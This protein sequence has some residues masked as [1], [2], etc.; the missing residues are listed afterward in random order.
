MQIE[1]TIK[2]LMID[3]V[4]NSPSSSFAIWRGS[5]C[6]RSGSGVFEAN[7]IAVQIEN[8]TLPR[9]MTHDLLSNVI[10]D[11]HGEVERIVVSDLRDNTFFAHHPAPGARRAGRHRRAPQ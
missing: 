1:M 10:A 3:P 7:A 11:L 6:C 4:T 9:P 8:V 5:A 2:G